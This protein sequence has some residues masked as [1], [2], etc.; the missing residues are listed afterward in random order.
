MLFSLEPAGTCG[1]QDG[2]ILSPLPARKQLW[3]ARDELTWIAERSRDVGVPKVFGITIN[4]E[5]AKVNEY[6]AIT[7]DALAK[8]SSTITDENDA[9]WQEWCAGMDGL[10]SLVMLAASLPTRY[11]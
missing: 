1:V 5:M 2:F 10:G 3:K 7:E 11:A 9:N 4:G 6:A 8:S